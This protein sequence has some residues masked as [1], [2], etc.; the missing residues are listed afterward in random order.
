M[1]PPRGEAGLG[2]A[3]DEDPINMASSRLV[4]VRRVRAKIEFDMGAVQ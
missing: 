1:I 4:V 3:A 2:W